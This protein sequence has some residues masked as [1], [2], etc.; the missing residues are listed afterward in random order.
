MEVAKINKVVEGRPHIVDLIKNGEINYILNTTEGTQAIA[1]SANIRRMALQHKVYYSTTM[2]AANAFC[3]ALAFG[4]E[5]QVRRLQDLHRLVSE[6]I[7]Q[8]AGKGG[9]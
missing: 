7:S 1:D 8:S 9:Q 2:A 6:H 4:D 5:K 3:Q